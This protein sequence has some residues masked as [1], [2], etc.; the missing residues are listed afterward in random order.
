MKTWQT[1]RAMKG[2]SPLE[3]AA[4]DSHGG[5]AATDSYRVG[6]GG[7]RAMKG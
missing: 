7:A 6:P 5:T 2:R 3:K 1:R 4:E